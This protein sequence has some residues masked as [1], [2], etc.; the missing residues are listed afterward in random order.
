VVS[1]AISMFG[2]VTLIPYWLAAH[3]GGE[4]TGTATWNAFVHVVVLGGVFVLLLVP[5]LEQWVDHRV[6]LR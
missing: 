5:Q 1:E 2:L 6:M 3:G 4:T